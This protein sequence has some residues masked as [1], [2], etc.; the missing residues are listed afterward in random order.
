MTASK[1]VSYVALLDSIP[2]SDIKVGQKYQLITSSTN[3][4]AESGELPTAGE[5]VVSYIETDT[6][7]TG[8]VVVVRVLYREDLPK[9]V[10]MSSLTYNILWGLRLL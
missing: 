1:K 10:H 4:A 2:F 3:H 6:V 7:T 8:A 9:S 5:V